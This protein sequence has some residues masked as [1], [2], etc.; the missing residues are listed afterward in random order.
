MSIL[1]ILNRRGI[2]GGGHM[3]SN[4]FVVSSFHSIVHILFI[5]MRLIIIVS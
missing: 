4:D 3:V 1:S 2:L 5:Y